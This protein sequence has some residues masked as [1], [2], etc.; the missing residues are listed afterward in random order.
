MEPNT[1]NF[2][3]MGKKTPKISK[4]LVTL[5]L[6][7]LVI[8][9]LGIAS[10]NYKT[11]PNKSNSFSSENVALTDNNKLVPSGFP[12]NTPVETANILKSETLS[13]PDRNTTVYNVTYNSAKQMEDLYSIYEKYFSANS[14]NAQ[15]MERD[16]TAYKIQATNKAGD[17]FLVVITPQAGGNMVLVS[18]VAR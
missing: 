3:D 4:G 18:Y 13:Y 16:A 14:F 17:Q 2:I 12:A 1:T 5:I 11:A 9:V 15:T 6:V 10:A 7:G 8:L